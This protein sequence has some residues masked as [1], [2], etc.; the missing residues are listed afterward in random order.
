[1]RRLVR[2]FVRRLVQEACAGGRKSTQNLH[3]VRTNSAQSPTLRSSAEPHGTQ[4]NSGSGTQRNS[5]ELK[6]VSVVVLG[7]LG[8]RGPK[9]RDLLFH[10][11]LPSKHSSTSTT[12]I[13][14][15]NKY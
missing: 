1:M 14:V 12:S 8:P 10:A 7:G 13:E 4:W 5:T 11:T 6:A 3:K 15:I 9:A 2:R